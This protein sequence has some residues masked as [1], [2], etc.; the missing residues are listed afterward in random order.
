[1]KIYH[2]LREQMMSIQALPAN[3]VH[4]Q[5]YIQQQ[6]NQQPQQPAQPR[7]TLQQQQ[8]QQPPPQQANY[9]PLGSKRPRSPSPPPPQ[10][11]V[12]LYHGYGYKPAPPVSSYQGSPQSKYIHNMF[13]LFT[14]TTLY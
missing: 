10:V 11:P 6:Q 14:Y 9:K 2:I 12:S 5:L 1:M 4:Q 3:M 7:P 8:P 13:F